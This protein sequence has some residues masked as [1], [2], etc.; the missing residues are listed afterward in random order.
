MTQL[1]HKWVPSPTLLIC[2]YVKCE[3]ESSTLD[4]KVKI[5][6][7]ISERTYIPKVLKFWVKMWYTT[8]LCGCSDSPMWW[9]LWLASRTNTSLPLTKQSYASI[10]S[11]YF[12]CSYHKKFKC[13]FSKFY[14]FETCIA[15]ILVNN[16]ILKNNWVLTFC[17][18]KTLQVWFHP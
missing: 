11:T 3:L 14:T 5:Q 17:M 1:S 2:W 6:Q 7:H 10:L 18:I 13:Q 9:S 12:M 15:R 16:F 4:G 8:H